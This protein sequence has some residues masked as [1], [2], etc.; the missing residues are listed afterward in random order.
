MDDEV[1]LFECQLAT[2]SACRGTDVDTGKTLA[3]WFFAEKCPYRIGHIFKH[4][5]QSVL[6]GVMVGW[7]VVRLDRFFPPLVGAV[8][9]TG[10]IQFGVLK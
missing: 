6:A 2:F 9:E 1:E 10:S 7:P 3:A 5:L 4:V 8:F